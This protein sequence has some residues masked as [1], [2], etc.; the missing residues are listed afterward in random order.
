[1]KKE[2][3]SKPIDLKKL[4]VQG[5]ISER[6]KPNKLSVTFISEVNRSNAIGNLTLRVKL[7]CD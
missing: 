5:S 3:K 4:H 6:K 1:M 7:Q 2:A